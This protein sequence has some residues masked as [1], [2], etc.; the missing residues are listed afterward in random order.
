M[1]HDTCSGSYA[2]A[3]AS[4]HTRTVKDRLLGPYQEISVVIRDL[5]LS[6]TQLVRKVANHSA[7]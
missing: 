4:R 2:A 3:S 6:E 1:N 7:Y 5:N